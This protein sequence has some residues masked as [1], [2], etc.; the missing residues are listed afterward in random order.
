VLRGILQN[1]AQRSPKLPGRPILRPDGG[2]FRSILA[3]V[4]MAMVC[5]CTLFTRR[6]NLGYAFA[7]FKDVEGTVLCQGLFGGRYLGGASHKVCKVVPA[8]L[9]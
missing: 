8:R 5:V 1:A 4:Y 6:L 9:Q 2:H 7:N 3:S